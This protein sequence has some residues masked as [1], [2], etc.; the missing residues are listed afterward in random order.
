MILEALATARLTLT[1]ISSELARSLVAGDYSGVRAAPGWP[2]KDTMDGILM[3]VEHGHPSGWLVLHR[4]EVIGDCGIFGPPDADGH[5]EIGYGLAEGWRGRGLGTELVR[6]I[7][8]W[9]LMQPG[10]RAVEARTLPEN[11]ASRRVLTKAGFRERGRDAG[12]VRY[13]LAAARPPA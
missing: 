3:S 1:P 10:V 13:E 4:A 11:I 2:H 6:A 5:I 8:T 12:Q 9:L 7:V